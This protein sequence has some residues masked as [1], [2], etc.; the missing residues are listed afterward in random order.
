MTLRSCPVEQ[1]VYLG[2]IKTGQGYVKGSGIKI[3][4]HFRQLV[5]IPLP[6][7]FVKGNI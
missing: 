3:S 1:L 7:D 5:L 6:L 4:H 2:G